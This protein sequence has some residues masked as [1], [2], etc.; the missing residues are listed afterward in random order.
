M[1]PELLKTYRKD[2]YDINNKLTSIFTPA[3]TKFTRV[4]SIYHCYEIHRT[5]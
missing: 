1:S 5:L 3:I 2:D 4:L